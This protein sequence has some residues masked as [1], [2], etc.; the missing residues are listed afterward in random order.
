MRS[1]R[2]WFFLGVGSALVLALGFLLFSALQGARASARRTVCVHHLKFVAMAL[3]MYA[4]EHEGRYPD[5]LSALYPNY[6]RELEVL[7]CPVVQGKHRGQGGTPQPP[8]TSDKPTSAEIDALCSY[9]Y[10]P[11]LSPSGDKDTVIAYEKQDN[12]SG[13][14]RS[15]LYLDGRGAW[16]PPEN[17][18]DGPPNKTLPEGFEE[19][20]KN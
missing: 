17:W 20:R 10:V 15:L 11:G 8:F 18:R 2:K 16:E 1:R 12:H 5:S 3:K 13:M 19:E 14:G 7:I 4:E 6:L 9:A